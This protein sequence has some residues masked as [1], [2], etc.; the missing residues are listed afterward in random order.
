M[1]MQ[2]V[3]IKYFRHMLEKQLN[4]KSDT[5]LWKKAVVTF[6]NNDCPNLF[7][8]EI[9]KILQRYPDR[10]FQISTNEYTTNC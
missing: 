10:L 3:F 7:I 9:E 2:K 1:I 4:F 6:L 5:S 8:E